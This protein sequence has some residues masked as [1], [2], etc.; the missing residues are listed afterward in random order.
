MLLSDF[1]VDS[2]QVNRGKFS[3][4]S[5]QILKIGVPRVFLTCVI[6]Q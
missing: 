1:I 3:L 2:H 4:T 6:C 5:L